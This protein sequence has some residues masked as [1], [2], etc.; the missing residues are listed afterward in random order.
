MQKQS[1]LQFAAAV[2]EQLLEEDALLALPVDELDERAGGDP[3][4]LDV[5]RQNGPK[6][7]QCWYVVFGGH[8]AERVS[9]GRRSVCAAGNVAVSAEFVVVK[10][11]VAPRIHI[12]FLIGVS[13]QTVRQKVFNG[14]P[15]GV[16]ECLAWLQ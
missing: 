6:E 1:V 16:V 3:V 2:F 8:E 12:Q 11:T 7:F 4:G 10:L 15:D 14:V 13:Q 9:G 5:R